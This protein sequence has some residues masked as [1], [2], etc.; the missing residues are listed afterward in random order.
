MTFFPL[1]HNKVA[2]ATMLFQ[3]LYYLVTI[4]VFGKLGGLTIPK[5]K[6]IGSTHLS[7]QTEEKKCFAIIIVKTNS[8]KVIHVFSDKLM[9][10][11]RA[12][13]MF[14]KYQCL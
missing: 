3:Q 7:T 12:I 8:G 9:E 11:D 1:R 4:T 2:K 14:K 13:I 10:S 6:S 5:L